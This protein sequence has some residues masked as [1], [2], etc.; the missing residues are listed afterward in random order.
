[1]ASSL[2]IATSAIDVVLKRYAK[3]HHVVAMRGLKHAL[4]CFALNF[5]KA[6]KIICWDVN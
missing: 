6:V 1:M 5:D 2:L 4:E 3:V